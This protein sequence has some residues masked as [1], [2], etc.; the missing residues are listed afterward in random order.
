MAHISVVIV[1]LGI[2]LG[3]QQRDLNRLTQS[4]LYTY[5]EKTNNNTT[6]TLYVFP[7]DDKLDQI[8]DN[9]DMD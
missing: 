3:L 1:I 9:E 8:D 7:D 6:T 4:K 2:I 5:L